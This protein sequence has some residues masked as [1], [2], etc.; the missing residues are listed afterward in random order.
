MSS[1]QTLYTNLKKSKSDK[2][3]YTLKILKNGM[4]CLLISDPETTKSAAS[5]VVNIGSLLDPKEYQGL[6][7]FCEHMLFMGTKKYPL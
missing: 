4:K 7:H 2:R 3:N 1:D 6:A 5:M